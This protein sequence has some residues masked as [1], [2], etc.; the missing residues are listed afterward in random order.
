MSKNTERNFAKDEAVEN[1]Y[2]VYAAGG[3]FTQHDLAMNVFIKDSVWRQSHAK[4]ELQS[5]DEIMST[6]S[7]PGE[8]GS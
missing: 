2:T 4:F 5:F 3:I 7:D 6:R 8:F 1:A